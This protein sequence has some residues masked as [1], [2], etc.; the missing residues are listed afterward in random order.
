MSVD[1]FIDVLRESETR[2]R[3]REVGPTTL[4]ESKRIAVRMDAQRQADKQRTRFVGKVEQNSPINGRP[5]Q[6]TE[7]QMECISR[8][9][10]MLSRSVQN[11]NNQQG[12]HAPVNSRNFPPHNAY[13]VPRPDR[14]DYRSMPPQRNFQSSGGN[15][16]MNQQNQA[17]AQFQGNQY[18]PQEN[19][20]EP[21]QRPRARLN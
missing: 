16:M 3:L 7:Q 9:I 5:E 15:P 13:C 18:R 21:T 17:P 8:R 6:N 20:W 4:A 19:F 10:D 1:H 14:F 12:L 2:L 11:L